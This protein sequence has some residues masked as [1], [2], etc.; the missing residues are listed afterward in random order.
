MK[1]TRGLAGNLLQALAA[2]ILYKIYIVLTGNSTHFIDPSGD[3]RTPEK[4]KAM[5]VEKVLFSRHSFEGACANL[6]IEHCLTKP[7]HLWPNGQG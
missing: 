6:D 7:R 2:A 3:I 1:V 5:L 4:I